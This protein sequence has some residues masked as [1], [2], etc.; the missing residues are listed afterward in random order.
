VKEMAMRKVVVQVFDYSLDG[1]LG[2]ED[3]EFSEFCRELPDDRGLEAWR[4]G[5]YERADV[6]VMGRNMYQGASQYFP[7]A[8][9]DHPY[10][11]FMNSCRKVVF[12]STL[13]S[14]DWANTT[15]VNGDTA[16]EIEKLRQQ[17]DGDIMVH[18]GIRFVQALARLDLADEYRLSVFPFLAGSGE[19]LFG[20]IPKPRPLELVSST[21]FGNGM[22]GLVYRRV[23]AAG[24]G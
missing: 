1:V 7:T 14:A 16:A 13:T 15:I 9:A 18:G 12:S 17:G 22:V 2:V 10:A 20:G 8:P 3:T 4:L 24:R 11:K 21:S 5:S 23:T 6:H 19:T